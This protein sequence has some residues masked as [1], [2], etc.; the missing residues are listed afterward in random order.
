SGA[1]GTR[2]QADEVLLG[3]MCHDG[4]NR[5]ITE[6]AGFTLLQEHEGGSANMP[7]GTEYWVVSSAGTDAATWTI[8]TG[9]VNSL[10]RIATFKA[11]AGGGGGPTTP[12]GTTMT[13]TGVGL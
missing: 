11:A 5:A 4:T 3:C 13:L 12:L 6:G 1:T 9:A 10:A 7:I 2:A 8:G